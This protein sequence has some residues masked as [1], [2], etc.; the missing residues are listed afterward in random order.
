MKRSLRSLVI[1]GLVLSSLLAVSSAWLA[2]D[3]P[4]GLSSCGQG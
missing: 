4:D 3:A 2:D 1:A